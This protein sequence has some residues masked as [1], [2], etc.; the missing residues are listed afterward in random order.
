[1]D[2]FGL[3]A[4]LDNISYKNCRFEC[5]AFG[6][7]NA[8]WIQVQYPVVEKGVARTAYARRWVIEAKSTP[9]QVVAT[10][11]KACI[12]VEEHEA[13]E[14]FLYKGAAVFYPHHDIDKLVEIRKAHAAEAGTSEAEDRP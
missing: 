13:R 7:E 12:T 5:G 8:F 1:M 9:W 11:L 10:A 6:L 14:A 4:I 2:I 3:R